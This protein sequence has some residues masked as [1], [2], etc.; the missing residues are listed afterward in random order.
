MAVSAA[1]AVATTALTIPGIVAYFTGPVTLTLPLSTNQH[2]LSDVQLG[3]QAHFTSVEVAI[4]AL[5]TGEAALLAW[6]GTLSHISVLAVLALLF[7]LA[8]RLRAANLFTAASVWIIGA[9]GA[10]LAVAGSAAQVLDQIARGRLA[11]VLGINARTAGEGLS[12][13]AH[14]NMAPVVA[15]LVL[16]LVAGVFQFGGR[17]QKDTE[18]LV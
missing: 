14:F 5:P 18:G 3:A 10:V 6:A 13:S 11:E 1:A 12:F 8:F 2:T 16:I 4:P 7:L 9:C 15:G 17:L